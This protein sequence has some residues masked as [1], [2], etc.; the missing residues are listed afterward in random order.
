MLL[1]LMVLMALAHAF[2]VVPMGDAARVKFASSLKRPS[3]ATPQAVATGLPPSFD[4][5]TKWPQVWLK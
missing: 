4:F 1:L 2:P 5:R 3:R